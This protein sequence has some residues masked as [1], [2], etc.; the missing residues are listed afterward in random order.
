MM[1]AN[2]ISPHS[3]DATINYF[4]YTNFMATDQVVFTGK[5]D[6]DAEV[7]IRYPKIEDTQA[8]LDYI[9]N[10]SNEKTFILFQ[11]EQMTLE[12]EQAYVE[13]QLKNIDDK[14]TV[15]LLVFNME[16][17]VGIAQVEQKDKAEKHLGNFG[18]SVAK[19]FRG[20]GIGKLL[21]QLVIQ[22]AEKNLSGMQIMTLSVFGDNEVAQDLYKKFG[23]QEYGKL[24]GGIIHNG[25][26]VDHIYMYKEI[27][28]DL[29]V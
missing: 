15:M 25:R 6:K 16:K 5:T 17:L 9:N 10:L 19:E 26:L 18:I 29:S 20:K 2:W 22:E 12:E 8:M 27:N 3:F 11:G 23:F 7:F 14:K 13:R 4:C 24:P 1:R 28:Q 21:M